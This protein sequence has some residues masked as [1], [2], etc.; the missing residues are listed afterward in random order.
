V[1]KRPDGRALSLLQAFSKAAD[2]F[3]FG[4]ILWELATWQLPWE[5]L[6]VFQAC[7]CFIA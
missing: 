5:E 4:V 6:S 2:V 3:S 7:P 1:L